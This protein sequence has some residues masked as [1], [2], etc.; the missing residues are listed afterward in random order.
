[1]ENISSNNGTLINIM[2]LPPLH[3]GMGNPHIFKTEL[4]PH[5]YPLHYYKLKVKQNQRECITK[6]GVPT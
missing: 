6:I 4:H 2:D 5:R 1:M 3:R